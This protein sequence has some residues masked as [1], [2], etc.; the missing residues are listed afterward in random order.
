MIFNGL[1]GKCLFLEQGKQREGMACVKKCTGQMEIISKMIQ[2]FPSG[3]TEFMNMKFWA[4]SKM[5]ACKAFI[6]E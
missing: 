1:Y 6:S 4:S 3:V 2:E 5:E